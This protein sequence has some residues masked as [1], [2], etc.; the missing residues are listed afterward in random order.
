MCLDFAVLTDR[1][2]P[3]V[4]EM[5]DP[6]SRRRLDVA[7]PL[8]L[9]LAWLGVVLTHLPLPY[10]SDQL[11]YLNTA[12]A[13]PYGMRSEDAPWQVTRYGLIIPARVATWI[14]G[15]SEAGYHLVPLLFTGGLV[16]ATY[17]LGTLLYGRWVGA[18][19]GL[20]AVTS[21]PMFTDAAALM[22]DMAAT[23]VFTA[24]V[25]LAVAV[26]QEKLPVRWWSVIAIGLLVGW[27]FEIREFIVFAWPLIPIILWRR[28]GWRGMAWLVGAAAMVG[29]GEILLSLA[30]YGDPLA[31]LHGIMVEEPN[32]NAGYRG[33]PRL[34]YLEQLPLALIKDPGGRWRTAL[35]LLVPIGPL[36]AW[37][38]RIA[39]R[40][41]PGARDAEAGSGTRPRYGA[42]VPLIWC[43][44]IWVPL[45]IEGGLLHPDHPAVRLEL[46]R[47]WYP[48]FPAVVL[49]G[50]GALW[51][52]A[53][54]LASAWPAAG[55]ERVRT[56]LAAAVVVVVGLGAVLTSVS[57][58]WRDPRITASTNGRA[59]MSAFRDWMH[60]NDVRYADSVLW[61][62]GRTDSVLEIYRNGPLGGIQWHTELRALRADHPGPKRGDLVLM[63]DMAPEPV[64]VCDVCRRSATEALGGLHLPRTWHPVFTPPGGVLRVYRVAAD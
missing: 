5:N 28:L 38:A 58:T 62:D 60:R 49:G 15:Y 32:P 61:T 42:A 48:L 25:A 43:A 8:V 46:V 17:A 47:Y 39:G 23:A 33:K 63:M 41:R 14:F 57:G 9:A 2:L 52:A 22:P 10:P 11:N 53:G 20:V 37:R 35:L 18:A 3:G 26:R 4:V 31:H 34:E 44:W 6:R 56:A 27:S 13:F 30:L 59:Q 40:L 1:L 54:W 64:H 51:L 21:A 24:A 19:A 55:R 50:L 45:T 16:A 36:I 7:I 29:V 12:E